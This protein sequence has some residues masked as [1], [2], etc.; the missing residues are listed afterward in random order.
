MV[1]NTFEAIQTIF[2]YLHCSLYKPPQ[3]KKLFEPS[4]RCT[5]R[6]VSGPNF[7]EIHICISS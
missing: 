4:D 3:Q 6:P 7:N 1:K 5:R 2:P